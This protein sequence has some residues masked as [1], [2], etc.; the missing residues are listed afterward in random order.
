MVSIHP[1]P[2]KQKSADICKAFAS[3]VDSDVE[4]Y[5]FFGVNKTN[6]A[7]W[8]RA[9]NTGIPYYYIDNSYFDVVRGKQFRVTRN[10]IQL[11]N[12]AGQMSDGK[13]FEKLGITLKPWKTG[14][15]YVLVCEQSLTYMQD[16][17]RDPDWIEK[18]IRSGT[19]D[20]HTLQGWPIKVRHWDPDK[21]KL[22]TTLVEDLRN[23]AW[24]VAHSSA[25]SVT[26]LIEGVGTVVSEMSAAYGF[27]FGAD[28]L[29]LMC[30]LADNQFSLAEM[31]DG[32]A[33]SLLNRQ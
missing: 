12:A 22:Q 29:P 2:G 27:P 14:G 1:I 6:I 8:N 10:A 13:R 5:V 24:L 3:G 18:T 21:L 31:K 32:T 25:A 30:A 19:R 9:R 4:G 20:G 28:R 11:R 33:W 15:N 23:A 16:I 17:A 7:A 26:A